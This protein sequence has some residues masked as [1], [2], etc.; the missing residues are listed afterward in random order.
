MKSTADNETETNHLL[1]ML[2]LACASN[3]MIILF[4]SGNTETRWA[5][6]T[7]INCSYL[8]INF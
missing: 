8:Q 1:E 6:L 4:V 5:L 2:G 3:G 7:E